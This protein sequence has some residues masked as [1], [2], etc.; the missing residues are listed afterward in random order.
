M[1]EVYMARERIESW[2]FDRPGVDVLEWAFNYLCKE[3]THSNDIS[4]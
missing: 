2:N 1:K 4:L 3:C